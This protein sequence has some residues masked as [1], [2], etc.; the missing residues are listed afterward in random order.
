M[1]GKPRVKLCHNLIKVSGSEVCIGEIPHRAFLL[2]GAEQPLIDLL[3]MLDGTRTVPRLIKT[4]REKHPEVDEKDIVATLEDLSRRNLLDDASAESE[5]L[6]RREMELYDRQILLFSLLDALGK[7]GFRY[8]ESLHSKTVTVF[9]MGGWGTWLSL[10]LALA[11]IGQL[12]L[13]DGD[14][15]EHSNLNRQVLYDVSQIGKPKVESAAESIARINPNVK[16]ET[17]FTFVPGDAA[18]IREML[19]ATDLLALCWANL[20]FFRDGT[21]EAIVHREAF[22][23]RIPV[24]DMAADPFEITAGPLLEN[25][26]DG[27]CLECIRENVRRTVYSGDGD[28]DRISQARLHTQFM[29]GARLVNAWQSSPSLS[30]MA[31][32]VADSAVK[33]LAGFK[34]VPLRE[35]RFRLTLTDLKSETLH[36]GKRSDCSWCGMEVSDESVRGVDTVMA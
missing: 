1:L 6:S 8:Q 16:V 20:S 4:F 7:P 11:G 36:A 29:N 19:G 13:F 32:L 35:K 18:K 27:P 17:H 34:D 33:F 12:R 21:T 24:I 26:G 30:V 9:G 2:K 28:T 5:V 22:S 3:E 14:T 31:G 23:A 15:V 25:N 10:H